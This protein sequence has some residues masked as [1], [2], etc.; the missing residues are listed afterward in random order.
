M[1]LHRGASRCRGLEEGRDVV[2]GDASVNVLITITK[3]T[4]SMPSANGLSSSSSERRFVT[5]NIRF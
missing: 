2:G 1:V 5:S 3:P 4:N